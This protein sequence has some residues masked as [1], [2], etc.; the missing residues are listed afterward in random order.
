MAATIAAP[1][2]PK[3]K[4][5]R[6]TAGPMKGVRA[7]LMSPTVLRLAAESDFPMVAA[8]ATKT[9]ATPENSVSSA[10]T[11]APPR[12]ATKAQAQ[13]GSNVSRIS[14]PCPFGPRSAPR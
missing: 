13:S 3:L 8:V 1:M 4:T 14:S 12:P 11:V 6:P 2:M 9:A 7:L 5:R 10:P